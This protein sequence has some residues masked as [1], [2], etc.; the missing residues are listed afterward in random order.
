MPHQRPHNLTADEA[1]ARLKAGNARYVAGATDLA[2]QAAR[3]AELAGGQ[4]PFVTVVA[5]ADSRVC[6]ELLFDEGLG[7]VFVIRV[8]GNIATDAVLGSIEYAGLHLGVNLV[9]VCGHRSCGAVTAAVDNVDLDGPATHSHIDALIDAIKPAVK[10]AR[11]DGVADLL[12]RA[13]RRNASYAAE[14]IAT[15][16]PVMAGLRAQGVRVVPA[17][18]DLASGGVSFG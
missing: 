18:Y 5:C 10:L 11:E 1:L 4:A 6:P 7:D 8:A 12:D 16:E 3:R 13:I 15:S 14:Q 9:V 2:P 17:Y